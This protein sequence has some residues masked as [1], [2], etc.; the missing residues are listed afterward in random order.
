[1]DRAIQDLGAAFERLIDANE[2]G[3]RAASIAEDGDRTLGR[4]QVAARAFSSLFP[5]RSLVA[6]NLGHAIWHHAPTF[7]KAMRI[8]TS[9]SSRHRS[10]VEALGQRFEFEPEALGETLREMAVREATA[11]V[12][13]PSTIAPDEGVRIVR[14]A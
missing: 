6:F 2:Q 9:G 12:D 10:L 8:T 1:M 4:T 11:P 5:D 7:A 14:V 3:L 13:R